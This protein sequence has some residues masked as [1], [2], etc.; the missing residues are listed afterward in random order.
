VAVSAQ[1][2]QEGEMIVSLTAVFFVILFLIGL[3]LAVT[4]KLQDKAKWRETVKL[5]RV[6]NI[7]VG[8]EFFLALVLLYMYGAIVWN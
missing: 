6:I 3:C 1:R 8:V 5:N 4:G 2:S 7:L